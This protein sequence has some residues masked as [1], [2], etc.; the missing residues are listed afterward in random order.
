MLQVEYMHFQ[1]LILD[2]G[3]V[4]WKSD[5]ECGQFGHPA[6]QTRLVH[7]PKKR[8]ASSLQGTDFKLVQDTVQIFCRRDVKGK[9]G[10]N[11]LFYVCRV[12]DRGKEI[13]NAA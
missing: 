4:P 11:Q 13:A 12:D 3:V 5:S 7:S 2:P 6:W 9:I 10:F 8:P 1:G